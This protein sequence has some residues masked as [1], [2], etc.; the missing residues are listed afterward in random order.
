MRFPE[1]ETDPSAIRGE[2]LGCGDAEEE[3]KGLEGRC[4]P[5]APGSVQADVMDG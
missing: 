4:A 2:V 1:W 5:A 3:G